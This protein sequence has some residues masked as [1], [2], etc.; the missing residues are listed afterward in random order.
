[1]WM[2]CADKMQELG[3]LVDD[4]LELQLPPPHVGHRFAFEDVPEALKLFQTGRSTGKIVVQV[5][6]EQ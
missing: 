4:M 6:Q 5:Q 1:M 2:A 3:K